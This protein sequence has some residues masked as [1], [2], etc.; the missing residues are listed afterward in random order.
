[1][2][3][4]IKLRVLAL[5]VYV[6]ALVVGAMVLAARRDLVSLQPMIIALAN[7]IRLWDELNREAVTHDVK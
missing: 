5:L 1:M 4:S 6:T 2:S 7:I 3:R